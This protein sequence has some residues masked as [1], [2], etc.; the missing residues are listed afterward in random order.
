MLWRNLDAYMDMIRHQV[1]FQ[2]AAFLL[3]G[4]FME[5][6]PQ[7]FPNGAIQGLP[8]PLGEQ[9]PRDTCNSIGNATGFDRCPT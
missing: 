3:P 8:A 9:T 2:D 1:A 4:E 5:N 6:G 7:G